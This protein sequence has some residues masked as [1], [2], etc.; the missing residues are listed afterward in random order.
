I[1]PHLHHSPPD[2]PKDPNVLA[3]ANTDNGF[4]NL[5]WY[6]MLWEL[7]HFWPAGSHFAFNLYRHKCRHILRGPPGTQPVLLLSCEG[8]MQ[9]NFPHSAY[10]GLVSCL[11]VKWHY[12]CCIVPNIGPLLTPI[13]DAIG[14]KFI[15]AILGLDIPLTTTSRT[16]LPI[17]SNQAN[18][19]SATQPSQQN[20]SSAPLTMRPLTSQDPSY[21]MNPSAPTTTKLLSVLP[22]PPVGMST[23]TANTPFSRPS[24]NACHQRSRNTPNALATPTHG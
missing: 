2:P 22:E 1:P 23:T 3:L 14:M 10:A 20:S 6:G 5:S 17:A 4:N 16:S 11:M 19:P 12:I 13:K 8:M 21:A 18:L 24:K 9:G 15:P 7:R